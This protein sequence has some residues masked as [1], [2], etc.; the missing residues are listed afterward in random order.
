MWWSTPVIPAI[1]GSTNRKI[2]VQDGQAIKTDTIS[3]AADAKR[4]GKC[5]LSKCEVKFNPQHCPQKRIIYTHTHTYIVFPT[6]VLYRVVSTAT[7]AK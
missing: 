3:K 2:A 4:A 7:S 6:T 1:V 5:L